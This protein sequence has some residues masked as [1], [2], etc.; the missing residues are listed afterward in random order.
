MVQA[1]KTQDQDLDCWPKEHWEEH[2]DKH[3]Y[4]PTGGLLTSICQE[5]QAGVASL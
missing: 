3:E 5:R 1:N 4:S 2:Q